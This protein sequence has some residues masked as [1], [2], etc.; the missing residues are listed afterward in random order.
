MLSISTESRPAYIF[1]IIAKTLSYF[2]GSLPLIYATKGR[3]SED[4]NCELQ[5]EAD[6]MT[7]RKCLF[8]HSLSVL[9]VVLERVGDRAGR[10]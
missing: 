7:Y 2:A 4:P 9:V 5:F 1:E 6:C 8:S 3:N 10:Y